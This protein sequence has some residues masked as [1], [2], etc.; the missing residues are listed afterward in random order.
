MAFSLTCGSRRGARLFGSNQGAYTNSID[1]FVD[2]QEADLK[3]ILKNAKVET[4]AKWSYKLL[5]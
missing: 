2:K 5:N 1:K 4:I 3:M